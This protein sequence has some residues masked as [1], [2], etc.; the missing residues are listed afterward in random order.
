MK[1][2]ARISVF[3]SSLIGLT[4]CGG[5]GS[6]SNPPVVPPPVPV[7]AIEMIQDASNYTSDE[8]ASAAVSIANEDY[9]GSTTSPTMTPA[10]AEA[11]YSLLFGDTQL[12]I[13]DIG[14]E[15]FSDAID[16]DGNVDGTY[17][18]GTSGTVRYEGFVDS[19]V[20]GKISVTYSNCQYNYEYVVMNGSAAI[21]LVSVEEGAY[22]V[23]M[24]FGDFEWSVEDTTN[25]LSGYVSYQNNGVSYETGYTNISEQFVTVTL[26][27]ASYK[28][29]MLSTES[30]SYNGDAISWEGDIYIGDM[31]KVS[32]A[33][34]AEGDYPPYL[35]NTTVL[36][37]GANK[38]ALIFEQGPVKFVVDTDDDDVY[39]MG[40][41]YGD[42]YELLYGNN[43]KQLVPI[44]DLSLPPSAGQPYLLNYY[45]DI[46]TTSTIVVE[47]GYYSDPDNYDD[48]LTISYRWYLNDVLLEE[49]TTETLPPYVAVFGDTLQVTM[50]VFDGANTVESAPLTISVLDSPAVVTVQNLPS[51]IQEGDYVEFNVF[52]SDPDTGETSTGVNLVAGPDGATVADSGAVSWQVPSDLLFPEQYFT[53]VFSESASE[54]ENLVE[55]VVTVKSDRNITLARSGLNV[56]SVN[57]AMHVADVDGDGQNE[58]VS[59]DANS[60]VFTLSFIDGR[61]QQTWQYPYRMPTQGNIRQVLISDVNDDGKD[62]I[63][64]VTENGISVI[65][66]MNKMA[67]TLFDT[68]EELLSATVADIDGDGVDEIIYLMNGADYNDSREA[69]VVSLDS[70]D[71][72]L[73]SFSVGEANEIAVANVDND[74]ALE[75]VTTTGY[76]YDLTTGENQWLK[77]DGFG[78]SNIAL[79]D[80]DGDGVSE[81]V[82]ADSWGYIEV[83]SAV[84]KVQLDNFDNFNTC[85]L[86]DTSLSGKSLL[87]VGDCQWGDVTAYTMVD[88]SLS[89][90]WRMNSQ[91][92]GV[93]SITTGDIDNDGSP[94]VLWGSG[95]SHSG[96]N[97]L[98]TADI[99]GTTVTLKEDTTDVQLDSFTS[100][101]WANIIS[102][103]ERAIYYVPSTQSGYGPSRYIM[104]NKEGHIELSEPVS[105]NWSGGNNA[106]ATDFNNDGA[107]DL[108]APTTSY[109]DGSFAAIQLYDGAIHWQYDASNNSDIGI[110]EALDMNFDGFTDAIVMIGSQLYIFDVQNQLLIANYNYNYISSLVPFI[111]G[112]SAY[113]ALISNELPLVIMKLT[114]AGLTEVDS[115]D[116]E[117]KTLITL[118]ADTDAE[119]ELACT[120][121][122]NELVIYDFSDD[123]IAESGRVNIP[124]NIYNVQADVSTEQN[125]GLIGVTLYGDSYNSDTGAQLISIGINGFAKWRSPIFSS[126]PQERYGN[127]KV[128]KSDSGNIEV[129]LSSYSSAFWVH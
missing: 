17:Q 89:E 60:N 92:H 55:H 59:T 109:Y 56:P 112:D 16:A 52:I 12:I 42:V 35:Y 3:T 86:T 29:D 65:T 31:G 20:T 1:N 14:N 32:I 88:G 128:R 66:D 103:D 91:D 126:M 48:E 81:I 9:K 63:L 62:D 124:E 19:N 5:G 83:Y 13:P 37:E 61:Y 105:E 64:V 22:H 82:G 106:V 90:V 36:L 33:L 115:V 39:D 72:A 8:L 53:F 4:A 95:V 34:D 119:P 117:C 94:E 118:N 87:L 45:E 41:Y 58:L 10:I 120:N 113:V 122:S 76:V 74:S 6:S 67:V 57:N 51:D 80:F 96:A 116:T 127:L 70:P 38:S 11:A 40:V 2:F 30:F 54:S 69:F 71:V 114:D 79:P 108:F 104:L 26:G 44:D 47:P 85:D 93:T 123:A 98:V 24:Y 125:Q 43:D 110:I 100:S 49:Y 99:S 73:F 77:G 78:S 7:T 129:Q 25:R 27:E 102:E 97:I 21:D 107:G 28:F 46:F 15:D 68:E 84:T 23:V 18:C 75:L 50:V 121:Y 101:G 111:S